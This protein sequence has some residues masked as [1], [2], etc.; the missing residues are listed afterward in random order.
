MNKTVKF[1][2]QTVL[3]AVVVIIIVSLVKNVL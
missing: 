1:L 2:V 3:T